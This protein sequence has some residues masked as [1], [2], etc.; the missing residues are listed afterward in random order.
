MDSDTID[1]GALKRLRAGFITGDAGD[2][3]YWH[4]ESDL[5]SYDQTFAQRIGWKWDYVL[6]ELKTHGWQPPGGD[7]VDWGCGT[8]IATR[9]VLVNFGAK[10]FDRVALCDRSPLAMKFAAQRVR[11]LVPGLPVWLEATPPLSADLLLISHVLTELSLE[12]EQPLVDL[13]RAAKVVIWV[14]PGTFDC[15]RRLIGI[16]EQLRN[17]HQIYA[18][19]TH[20]QACGIQAESNAQHWCHFFAP[21]PPETFQNRHWARFAKETG[22]D[23]RSLPVSYLVLDRRPVPAAPAGAVRVIGS[24]RLRKGHALVLGCDAAGVCE[25][26]LTKRTLPEQFTQFRKGTAGTFQIWKRDDNEIITAQ[27]GG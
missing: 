10:A 11:R 16:R 22:I 23:L 4:N 25:Y 27:A 3:D 20:R 1:W 13:A 21:S 15:S 17:D 26:R 19:C 12:Q 9:A 24:A 2:A 18:P 6:A 14:E 5:V 8:G 7:A